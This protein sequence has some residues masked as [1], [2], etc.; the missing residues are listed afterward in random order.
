M[1]SEILGQLKPSQRS[2]YWLCM[3]AILNSLL[4]YGI[5]KRGWGHGVEMMIISSALVGG[6]M[7]FIDISDKI[8]W[9]ADQLWW[10]RWDYLSIKPMRH[11][12]RI[13]ELTE[14]KVAYHPVNFMKG[15]PFDRFLLISPDDEIT[16][17]VDFHRREGLEE[18]LE[19]IYAKRPEIF[20]DQAVL[21][22]MDGAF[23]D[24][25]RYKVL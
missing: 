2:Y 22:F 21:D 12:V 3:W 8:W 7:F 15:K 18:L 5:Y 11:S 17:L 24:W 23:S 1:S 25:W 6:Y 4:A 13:D 19:L 9:S 10:R 20:V 16:I 14:V